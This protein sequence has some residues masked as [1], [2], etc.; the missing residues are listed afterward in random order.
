MNKTVK[1]LLIALAVIVLVGGCFGAVG[2]YAHRELTKP[3]F[4][5]SDP[6][7]VS[8]RELPESK[9]EALAYLKELYDAAASADDVEA[10]WHTDVKLKDYAEPLVT[11]MSEADEKVVSYVFKQAGDTLKDSVYPKAESVLKGSDNGIFR[12]DLTDKD[13]LDFTAAQGRTN[14]HGEHVDDNIYYITL[15]VDPSWIDVNAIEQGEIYARFK[16]AISDAFTVQDIHFEATGA[17]IACQ[18]ERAYDEMNSFEITRSYRVKATVLPTEEYSSLFSGPA[19]VELPYESTEKIS[20]YYYGVHFSER[21]I[22][23]QPGDWQAIPALVRVHDGELPENFKM[24]YDVSD[25]TVASIDADGV[26]RIESKNVTDEK[27]TISMKLTYKGHEYTDEIPVYITTMEVK[28][29]E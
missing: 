11:P 20:F 23:V 6:K 9:S 18:I 4:E 3:R 12:F 5:L 19:E 24:E 27:I 17:K 28:T 7:V 16:Q 13:V 29:D 26:L 22:A 2:F 21:W 8:A 15:D 14:D 25:E 1:R 10:S